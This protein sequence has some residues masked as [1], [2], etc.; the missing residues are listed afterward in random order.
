[1]ENFF[2]CAGDTVAIYN[3]IKQTL[4]LVVDP[5]SIKNYIII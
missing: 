1:M 4:I 2:K 5:L 3:K